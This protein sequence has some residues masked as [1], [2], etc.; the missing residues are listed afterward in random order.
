MTKRRLTFLFVTYCNDAYTLFNSTRNSNMI[1]GTYRH[2]DNPNGTKSV[3]K[4]KQL[5]LSYTFGKTCRNFQSNFIIYQQFHHSIADNVEL[6]INESSSYT[7]IQKINH[8]FE[9]KL[10]V[11]IKSH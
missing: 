2:L 8:I 1:T 11:E 4:I 7:S 9:L 6:N 3:T 10:Y 5:V